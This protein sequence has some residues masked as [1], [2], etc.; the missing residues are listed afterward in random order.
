[1]QPKT[2]QS[3]TFG[4]DLSRLAR[5]T[6]VAYV[7]ATVVLCCAI[8]FS[9]FTLKRNLIEQSRLFAFSNS[10]NQLRLSIR[11]S[12]L[13][14]SDLK[15]ARKNKVPGSLIEDKI[16]FHLDSSL[17]RIQNS[18][19]QTEQH[20]Q[21]LKPYHYYGYF[22]N[23][24]NA[25]PDDI[26]LKLEQYLV[27][28]KEISAQSGGESNGLEQL[29]L[30]VEVTAARKGSLAKS[31]EM[32]F[33]RLLEIKS[34]R[35]ESLQSTH[36]KL[37]WIALFLIALEVLLIFLPLRHLLIK[38]NN[39][40]LNAHQKLDY[41][42][43]YDAETGLLN[44]AGV[45]KSLDI[46]DNAEGRGS[47]VVVSITNLE[48]IAQT[49]GPTAL[50]IFFRQ[51]VD[52]INQAFPGVYT[53]FRAG[54]NRYGVIYRENSPLVDS[55]LLAKVHQVLTERQGV[56]NVVIHPEIKMGMDIGFVNANNI[57]NKTLNAQIA[58][59]S[60]D[61]LN[62]GIPV[63]DPSMRDAIEQENA[64]IDRLKQALL[65]DEF[66]PY[67]Q[68][69]VHG[70]SGLASGMEAL[71]RWVKPD[72][73]IVPPFQFIP[74]A[75]KSG[76]I[77]EI[78]W[79]MLEKM[80]SDYKYWCDS[81][82]D[83]GRIA[84]NAAEML[85]REPDYQQRM[86]KILAQTNSPQCPFDLEITENVAFTH[87]S[88]VITSNLEYSRN[89]GMRIA[90]DDFGTGYASL[91]SVVELDVDT[92]KVDKSFVRAMSSDEDSKNI[93]LLIIKLCKQLNKK[94]VVEGVETE[95]EWDIC[96]DAGCDEIQ[97]FYFYKP[98]PAQDVFN[99]LQSEQLPRK[100][101]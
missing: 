58:S 3:I 88:D 30:P 99:S 10:A 27:R 91:S 31:Y 64:L 1:M 23:I 35:S 44:L 13:Y 68:I 90:L 6:T 11:E 42:A 7:A 97:G 57:E 50:G 36:S 63:Y 71:C 39:K 60:Y 24:F 51:F 12:S 77:A 94:C 81:G 86:E 69:K 52:K 84:F 80:A 5:Y 55:A 56:K 66:V 29:W 70:E 25:Q 95:Q 48:Y 85:L 65:N 2:R 4:Q 62:V 83:P 78:T 49:T 59:Q 54:D 45:A 46:D 72:G 19:Q 93:V 28:L 15:L 17:D 89:A 73:Q 82:L 20:L 53:V 92:I 40:L 38:V 96:R 32:A 21:Q 22:N 41:Q 34:E 67:Y 75:E 61:S 33:E 87:Q 98:A 43:S 8:I 76:L 100:A 16:T 47:M 37:T 9:Y 79:V 14:L 101:G 26:W 74:T 18:K